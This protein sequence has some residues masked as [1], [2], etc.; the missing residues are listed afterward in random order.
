LPSPLGAVTLVI[1]SASLM[2]PVK[3]DELAGRKPNTHQDAFQCVLA[4]QNHFQKRD[5]SLRVCNLL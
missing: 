2:L 1:A 3:S 5:L 4:A